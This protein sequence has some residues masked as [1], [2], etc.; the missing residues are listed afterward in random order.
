MKNSTRICHFH[1]IIH[2]HINDNAVMQ[3][4]LEI[5]YLVTFFMNY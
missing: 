4:N 3:S 2:F 5:Y 1:A